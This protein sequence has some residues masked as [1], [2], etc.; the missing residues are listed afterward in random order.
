MHRSPHFRL[1]AIRRAEQWLRHRDLPRLQMS[2]IIGLTGL[3]GLLFSFL[4]LRSGLDAM[5]IRYPA[6]VGLAYGVFLLLLRI[7]IWFQARRPADDLN[8]WDLADALSSLDTIEPTTRGSVH[9]D[10]SGSGDWLEALNLDDAVFVLVAL[11]A[12]LA[13]ALVC[14]FVIWSA[15]AL[16]AEMLVDGVVMAGV[17][18][19]LKATDRR[20]WLTGAL[21]RTW[22][23]AGTVALFFGV[24]GFALQQ[25]VPEA[26][27]IGPVIQNLSSRSR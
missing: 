16:L 23:Q 26:R 10:T 2:L 18:H 11:A 15:P 7:W 9:A 22:L 13:G 24:A 25:V 17:Y 27:S 8:P 21:R 14:F 5:W 1:R 4:L 12:L 3:A 19:K 20:S 6:A